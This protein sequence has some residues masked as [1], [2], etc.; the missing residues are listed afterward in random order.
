MLVGD[1]EGVPEDH[2]AVDNGLLGAHEPRL[3]ERWIE[4]ACATGLIAV[5]AD[6]YRTLTL[7]ACGRAVMA[8]RIEDVQMYV[9]AARRCRRDAPNAGDG[10]L[11]L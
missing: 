9:S 7:T 1:T 5:S 11:R 3:M 8:G 4:S 10:V 2:A 6:R